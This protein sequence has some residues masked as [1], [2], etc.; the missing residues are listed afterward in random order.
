VEALVGRTIKPG[1]VARARETRLAVVGKFC[2]SLFAGRVITHQHSRDRA[3]TRA[4]NSMGVWLRGD[5]WVVD[6][7]KYSLRFVL[8]VAR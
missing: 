5:W 3:R 4:F 7:E 1:R 6:V 8:I 2:G